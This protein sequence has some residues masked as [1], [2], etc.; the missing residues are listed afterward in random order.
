M[1]THSSK[2][3]RPGEK[4]TPNAQ[5][6]TPNAKRPTPNAEGEEECKTS[7]MNGNDPL[8]AAQMIDRL[9][10]LNRR[11]IY[12]VCIV[13]CVSLVSV[14]FLYRD[15]RKTAHAGGELRVRAITIVDDHGVERVKIAAPLPD[16][17]TLGKR[18]KRDDSISGILIY[19]ARGNER[20]GYA[21]DNSVGNSFLTLDSDRM[22]AVTLVAYPGG[23]AELGVQNEKKDAVALSAVNDG[24]KVRLVRAGETVSQ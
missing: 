15:H 22:Q 24:P 20:G 19:D 6:R 14:V 7:G 13:S 4:Q 12:L 5:R 9:T 2:G 8:D 11:L 18:G 16:P 23:G 10:K 1:T 17:I 3:S 21:T